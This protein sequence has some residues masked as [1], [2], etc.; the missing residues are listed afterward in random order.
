MNRTSQDRGMQGSQETPG[1]KII[2][3]CRVSQPTCSLDIQIHVSWE[4]QIGQARSAEIISSASSIFD[5]KH[6]KDEYSNIK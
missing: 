4:A 3:G 1:D 6:G 2:S 5:T